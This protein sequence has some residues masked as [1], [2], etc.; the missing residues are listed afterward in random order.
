MV[1]NK[2]RYLLSKWVVLLD[3]NALPN[4]AS[5]TAEIIRQLKFELIPHS[6]PLYYPNLVTWGYHVLRTAKRILTWTKNSKVMTKSKTRCLLSFDHNFLHR[7]FQLC[8]AVIRFAFVTVRWVYFNPL[9]AEL[10]PIC[11]LLALLGAHHI[12]HISR[13]R[14]K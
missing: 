7:W 3:D 1:K 11:H 8:C 6:P 13:I 4:S 5:A 2:R 9:N 14:V 12:L 10:N